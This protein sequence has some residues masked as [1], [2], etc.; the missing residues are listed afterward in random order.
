MIFGSSTLLNF[1]EAAPIT[2][3]ELPFQAPATPQTTMRSVVALL[4][5]SAIAQLAHANL[6]SLNSSAVAEP[7]ILMGEGAQIDETKCSWNA[8]GFLC[9]WSKVKEGKTS[10]NLKTDCDVTAPVPRDTYVGDKRTNTGDDGE[11]GPTGPHIEITSTNQGNSEDTVTKKSTW[12]EYLSSPGTLEDEITFSSF[13]VYDLHMIATD[14]KG[15]APC[16]GCIAIVDDIPPKPINPCVTLAEEAD[17]DYDAANFVTAQGEES[18]FTSFYSSDNVDNNYGADDETTH[19]NERCD[20]K[21]AKQQDFFSPTSTALVFTDETYD[22]ICFKTDSF[23]AD[24][25]SAMTVQ[26]TY[27]PV[28]IAKKDADLLGLKCTR[29]CSKSVTLKEYYYD[30]K[31]GVSVKDTNRLKQGDEKCSFG[32]CITM[33]P[34]SLIVA[35]VSRSET[36]TKKT[37]DT[38]AGLPSTAAAPGDTDLHY[39]IPCEA[40]D[41]DNTDCLLKP[42]LGSMFTVESEWAVAGRTEIASGYVFWRYKTDASDAVWKAWS[43]SDEVDLTKESKD[44]VTVH[45]EGWS[46]CGQVASVDFTVYVHLQNPIP[47]VCDS[48]KSMFVEIKANQGDG[49]TCAYMDSDFFAV[50][51]AYDSEADTSVHEDGKVKGHFSEVICSVTVKAK[52]ASD[53]SE[54]EWFTETATANTIQVSKEAAFELVR[55]PKTVAFTVVDIK[56]TF[57]FAYYDSSSDPE[58][59]QCPTMTFTK[60]DCASP[61]MTLPKG[62]PVCS[63][64]A[65]LG[66]DKAG[67]FERCEGDMFT[68]GDAKTEMKTASTTC[69]TECKIELE[70]NAVSESSSIKRC[71]M[72]P[73]PEG[74]LMA[75]DAADAAASNSKSLAA[76]VLGAS[77]MVAIVA[78]V[79]ARH[80]AESAARAKIEND[81]YY[82]LLE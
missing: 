32:Q 60:E 64:D 13:G 28:N 21:S 50:E 34:K 53:V 59:K 33:P 52:D 10:L 73:I 5:L 26:L 80:R 82:P 67:L 72:P 71:E 38:V 12:V 18:T 69:C 66:S 55:D 25:V 20:D 36:A 19:T 6:L 24:L 39:S 16:D 15:K 63:E 49:D 51:F 76:L 2:D 43:S 22:E 9:G 79:V 56:C 81:V 78:L 4:A 68:G 54:I 17:L 29:C 40:F 57:R 3:S 75:V 47:D 45:V 23:V 42:S 31:C 1:H 41:S 48:F 35:T 74:E 58:G 14:Y 61:S 37:T 77:A 65:C 46:H 27:D 30:Y 70:C 62:L 44:S 11:D 7:S 8:D